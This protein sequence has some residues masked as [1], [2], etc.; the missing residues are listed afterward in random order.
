MYTIN[1]ATRYQAIPRKIDHERILELYDTDA[2][3]EFDFLKDKF[4]HKQ[5]YEAKAHLTLLQKL[6]RG[7]A[8]QGSLQNRQSRRSAAASQQARSVKA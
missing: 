7:L 6:R 4:V 3:E 5:F 1:P 8:K 2:Q